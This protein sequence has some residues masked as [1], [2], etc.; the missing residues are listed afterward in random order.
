MVP[1]PKYSSLQ[2]G[3][4]PCGQRM[5]LSF[6]EVTVLKVTDGSISF[7]MSLRLI[8]GNVKLLWKKMYIISS[9]R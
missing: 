2:M 5:F 8:L 4:G 9:C 3:N 1:V 7:Y 6:I